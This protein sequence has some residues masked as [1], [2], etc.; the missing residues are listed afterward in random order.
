M[1]TVS[2]RGGLNGDD[3]HMVACVSAWSGVSGTVWEELDMGL[4][5]EV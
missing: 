3:P 1:E 2:V 4:L 5:E